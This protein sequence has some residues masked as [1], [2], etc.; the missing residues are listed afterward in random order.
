MK[1]MR[2][3]LPSLLLMLTAA[4]F[5]SNCAFRGAE[6]GAAAEI[7]SSPARKKEPGTFTV[8]Y[9]CDGEMI[10]TEQ[11]TEGE[12]PQEI[13]TGMNGR[14]IV[15][16]TNTNGTETD[17][18]SAKIAA[19]TVFSAVPGPELKL[20]G[21]Y[22]APETDGLFHP[23]DSFTRS[24]AA[25]AV[26]AL[27]AEKPKGETFLKDVTSRARCWEAATTLVTNGY[28]TLTDGHFCPDDPISKADMQS[29]LEKLFSP[30]AVR[31]AMREV[32]DNMTRAQAAAIINDLL[33]LTVRDDL[34]YFPDVFP[35]LE[36]YQ[37]IELAGMEGS[38]WSG[39]D[40]AAPGFVNLEG[41]LYYVDDN[42][43]FIHDGMVGT[44]YFDLTGRYTSGDAALDKYTAD[45][46]HVQVNG[47]MSREEMLRAVYVYVRD[48]YLY[49]KRDIYEIG[50][51]GWEIPEALTMFQTGKGNCYNFTA[52][53]WALARGVGFDAVCHSG[54]VGVDRNPH[55]WVEIEFDGEPFIFDVE[56][57][58]QYRLIDDCITSMYKLD[59]ERGALWSYAR[60][61][62]DD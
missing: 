57:E 43:Y 15:A 31:E 41:Y 51:T 11:V 54:L 5:L 61:P 38:V 22:I 52:A 29:L 28:M 55:S 60:E 13:P 40:R 10:G 21:G 42:G 48:H 56:T 4:L 44:L 33:G 62:Y 46:I 35:E 26:Y 59:Y 24:A 8:S 47:K 53:F 3:I 49:M 12:S 20:E 6:E 30:G 25:R 39:E 37:A 50:E 2:K 19:D 18:W 23:F 34:P 27:L 32:G 14:G 16:W 58:M 9:F 36:D 1:Q 17:V 7:N 45:I